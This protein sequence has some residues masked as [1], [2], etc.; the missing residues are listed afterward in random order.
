MLA[1]ASPSFLIE[2]VMRHKYLPPHR[3][4]F[5][6][7]R[8][9][10]RTLI[11]APR[12]HG[13]STICTVCFVIARVLRN[14]DMRVLLVS[15][16]DDQASA[17][18]REVR[19]NLASPEFVSLF[20]ELKGAQW[21][22]NR[23][24]IKS[25]SR[26]AKEATIVA[27]GI[28]GALIS[29]HY[30][31]IVADD[32]VDDENSL[33]RYQRDRLLTV[34]EK[35]LLPT[36]QPGGEIHVLGVRYNPSDL[37]QTLLNSGAYRTIIDKALQ[38]DG[39]AL[40]EELFPLSEVLER[41]RE[42]RPSIFALQYQMD[43]SMSEGELF[44]PEW[45]RHYRGAVPEPLL[46]VCDGVDPQV[47]QLDQHDYYANIGVGLG[48]SGTMYVLPNILRARPTFKAKVEATIR[49]ARE[50]DSMRTAIEGVGGFGDFVNAVR[51]AAPDLAVEHFHAHKNKL[52]R[53][54]A[55]SRFV[56]D[57]KVM[58]PQDS[59]LCGDF[60]RELLEFP[61]GEH[62]DLV[63]AF[64]M[65][66]TAVTRYGRA[67]LRERRVSELQHIAPSPE[68]IERC[69]RENSPEEEEAW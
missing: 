57:G 24:T 48:E 68:Y 64:A 14:P 55:A 38:E 25:R 23:L 18:L 30:E 8:N 27:L 54:G 32:I 69:F 60:E 9:H 47:G 31:M 26:I 66:V 43:A 17:L 62:D 46:C 61:D 2:K 52:S 42:I 21:G 5:E 41:K 20:G 29:G 53:A 51:E 35:E 33:T 58:F 34:F 6:L 15:N 65:A 59:P 50:R 10:P 49:A 63:D 37:Y 28:N 19:E 45:F 39:S 3:R 40:C 16:T 44:R 12:G 36:L 1:M 7:Q 13:K 56:E 11:L 67:A 22:H 4:W